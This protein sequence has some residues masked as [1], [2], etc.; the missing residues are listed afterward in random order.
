MSCQKPDISRRGLLCALGTAAAGASTGCI[1]RT[2]VDFEESGVSIAP[3]DYYSYT[4][5]VQDAGPASPRM[6]YTVS[7]GDGDRFDVLVFTPDGFDEYKRTVQGRSRDGLDAVEELSR[8]GVDD[9]TVSRTATMTE[10]AYEVVVDHTDVPRDLLGFG[11]NQALD[12]PI[13]VSVEL[14]VDYPGISE[15]L[16]F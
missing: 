16:P 11:V 12:E 14:T 4:V 10:D 6:S 7:G 1:S 9:N 2:P 5:E 15:R 8:A 3:G 13:T